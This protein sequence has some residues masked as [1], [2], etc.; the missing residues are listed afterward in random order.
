MNNR[1]IVVTTDKVSYPDLDSENLSMV[2]ALQRCG[3]DVSLTSWHEIYEQLMENKELEDILVIRT[4]W[5]YPDYFDKFQ[6]FLKLVGSHNIT[7]VNPLD[8]IEWNINKRYL[9]DLQE[10]GIPIVPCEYF[11]AGSEIP[12][13]TVKSV[14]KPVIGLGA[15]GAKILDGG[16]SISVEVDSIVN[17]FRNSIYDGELSIVMISGKPELFIKKKPSQS[18]W[19]VQPQYGGEYMFADNAPEAAINICKNNF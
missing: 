8:I 18:D 13:R 10:A 16:D 12:K 17:P 6:H 14:V 7:T 19:R 11:A 5:D 3:L 1:I 4:V 2:Q 9:F 15:S